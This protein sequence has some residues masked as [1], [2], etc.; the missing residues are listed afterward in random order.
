M[1][2]TVFGTLGL[3]ALGVAMVVGA[4]AAFGGFGPK[5]PLGTEDVA[6][7]EAMPE[8]PRELDPTA[9][10]AEI[11]ETVTAGDVSW[12]VNDASHESELRRYTFPP[13]KEPGDF[14]SL[15]F[16]VE[17]VSEEPV[18]LTEETISI[19]DSEGNEYQPAPDRNDTY[20][21]HEKNLLYSDTGLIK[22]GETKEGKVNVEVLPH[23]SGFTAH[24]GDTDPN[25]S[26][27]RYVDLG[28]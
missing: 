7:L 22:P 27:G 3:L 23:S 12:T 24:L 25:S 26:Q 2:R 16:T 17:N 20:V 8:Q 10:V 5:Q 11:G 9:S 18:T 1:M 14:V 15:D 28:F 21:E 6:G 4:F 19:L 13:H